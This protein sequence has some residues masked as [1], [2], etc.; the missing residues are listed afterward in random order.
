M[1]LPKKIGTGYSDRVLDLPIPGPCFE[2]SK[3]RG[4]AVLLDD[5]NTGNPVALPGK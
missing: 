3:F 1:S 2:A 4:T 5:Y